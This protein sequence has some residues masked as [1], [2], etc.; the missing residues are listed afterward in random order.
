MTCSVARCATRSA[1]RT[2]PRM[3]IL[4][5]PSRSGS[6]FVDVAFHQVESEQSTQALLEALLAR[7]LW[8]FRSLGFSSLGQLVGQL[9]RDSIR[10]HSRAHREPRAVVSLASAHCRLEA[11]YHGRPSTRRPRRLD[12]DLEARLAMWT[13]LSTAAFGPSKVASPEQSGR[14]K[15]E[16][17]AGQGPNDFEFDLPDG[18]GVCMG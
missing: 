5:A 10:G 9:V 3:I 12:L 13:P 2:A 18:C 15:G 11:A 7:R 17:R 6:S 14:S 8:A 4:Q 16:S 1:R